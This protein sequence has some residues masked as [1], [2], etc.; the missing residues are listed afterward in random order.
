VR[1]S[2]CGTENDSG[3]KF[4]LECGTRLSVPCPTCSS[5]NP[6]GARFCGECGTQLDAAAPASSPDRLPPAE[7]APAAQRRLVSVLFADLVGFTP[8]AEERDA[9]EVRNTLQRYSDMARQIVERYG[10]S[11]E[12]FIGDAVMAVWGT[13]T[14]HEDDA[15]RAVRAALELTDAVRSL[16]PEIH[17]RAGVLTGEAA[18]TLGA[19]DQGMLAG[20]LVN[21]AARLQ[22]VAPAGSVLVGESTMRAA[23]AALAFE[24]A[25]EQVL[26]G[27]SVPI[28][29]WR[30]LRVVAQRRGAGRTETLETPFVG[31]D[32][33]FRLLR[34]LLHLS[35]RD[36]RARIVSVTGPAGIGKSRLAWELEK[37]IDG[38]VEPIYWHRGR[39]PAY[40]EGITFWA[41]GEMV[42]VR[43]RLAETDGEAITR[44]RVA[45]AVR[46]HVSEEN[47][48]DWISSALLTLLGH[49][50]AAQTGRELLFAAWRRFFEHVSARGTTV[51][52]FED[53][54][55]A[56][57][58]LLDFIGHLLDWSK[59]VPLLV[60]TLARP[61]LFDK[62]PNWGAGRRMLTA[63]ALDPLSEEHMR[64]LLAGL[65]PELPEQAV[66]RIVE[67]ADGIP[68]YAVETVRMLLADGRLEQVDGAYRPTGELGDL[69]V[70]DSLRS[71]ITSRLDAL[72]PDDRALLQDASVLGQSFA[73]DTLCAVTGIESSDLEPRLRQLVRRELLTLQADPRSPERGQYGFMQS[74]TREV[75]YSTLARPDRRA[76]HLAA[77]RHYEATGGDEVAGVLAGHYLAAHETSASGPEADAVAAQARVALRGAADRAAAL[78]GHEQA[79]DYLEQALA[80]T[81]EPSE[82]AQ[83][84]ERQASEAEWAG[85]Y[86]RSMSAARAAIELYQSV[87]DIAGVAR[88]RGILGIAL[89][90]AS[91]VQ[92]AIAELEPAVAELPADADPQVRADALAKLAR[93]YYRNLERERSLKTADQALVI[94]EHHL[95]R[96]TVAE[97]LVTKGTA[98]SM[99]AR[100]YEA[101]A[102]L[103]TGMEMARSEG[104]VPTALRAAANLTYVVA[105]YESFDEAERI[106]R[107]ALDLARTVGDLGQVV[108]QMG[109]LLVGGC[110]RGVRVNDLV[111]EGEEVLTMDLD[112]PDRVHLA[113]RLLWPR[114]L[115][116]DNVAAEIDRFRVQAESRGDPL[117]VADAYWLVG[118]DTAVRGEYGQ[119]ATVQERVGEMRPNHGHHAIAAKLAALDGDASEAQ[120]L[121]ERAATEGTAGRAD[122]GLR[123]C[124]R[125]A[126]AAFAGRQ[127]EALSGFRDAT[128]TLRDVGAAFDIG[129]LGLLMLRVLGPGVPEA[130]AAGEEALAIF[131][132]MGSQPMI[133]HVR[134]ALALGDHSPRATPEPSAQA[135]IEA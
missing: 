82:R 101:A 55:W 72:A 51:L 53:L 13:P 124:V 27:K 52:V 109:N 7:A 126:L 130:R 108:W 105:A 36:P 25:G 70:P 3:R 31:R 102:L 40:G 78:G 123:L 120:R 1:C 112:E 26:K 66:S 97:A 86:E 134:E 122:E 119:A 135:S 111:E 16:G 83:L 24:P 46:E 34:E 2:N 4:C 45:D 41:L 71:L 96:T 118:L 29:A 125:A 60:V 81:T 113:S 5:P 8:F 74:L 65:V 114:V 90:D 17:A 127:E 68:L 9:E 99:L 77:A 131:E 88:T 59:D 132:R 84:I 43:C 121:M 75:A 19:T 42:R 94:A 23:S 6:P 85:R 69:E 32:E 47:E 21:T 61:E 49:E 128:R 18:V 103:R 100:S 87:G 12:K 67:R 107:E 11:V 110:L 38:V 64:S 50:P 91:R 98:L 37:Y 93:A 89:I 76:R 73:L 57:S 95:L 79:A 28:S 116:G 129:R 92:E 30:A 54:H 14:A 133:A 117:D 63:I 39:C 10:G 22:S 115:R 56:D 44:Q 35:G 106:A 62:R 20:D 80:V 15:E 33:E 104:D 58:G 48:R